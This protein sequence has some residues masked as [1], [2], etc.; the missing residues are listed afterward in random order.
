MVDTVDVAPLLYLE[1]VV[2][3]INNLP[4]FSQLQSLMLGS[5]LCINWSI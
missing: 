3:H 1:E 2:Q 4:D 5:K